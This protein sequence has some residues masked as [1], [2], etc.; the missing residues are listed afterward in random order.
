MPRKIYA[1][2]DTVANE[3]AGPLAT[4]SNDTAAIR[5][6]GDLL[7]N[8]EN[9]A[10][11]AADYHLLSLGTILEH[12]AIEALTE[13]IM[14]GEAWLAAQKPNQLPTDTNPDLRIAK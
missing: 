3:L 7:S 10:K 4:H 6:F 1:I 14:T 13:V 8:V 9:I 5:F 11:H 12:H 2:L